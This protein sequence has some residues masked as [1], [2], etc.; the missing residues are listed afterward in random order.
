MNLHGLQLYVAIQVA[1]AVYLLQL[2]PLEYLVWLVLVH[3]LPDVF[4]Q[5][6]NV[7]VSLVVYLMEMNI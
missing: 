5:R 4:H 1:Q 2:A 3:A 7:V 6:A